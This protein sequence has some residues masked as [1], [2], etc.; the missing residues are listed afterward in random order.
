MVYEGIIQGKTVRLRSVEE[1]DAEITFKMRTDPEKAKY[2]HPVKGSVD[3]QRKFITKQ[4][5]TPGD[6]LFIIEDLQG[7]PIGMKGVY[8]YNETRNEV[9]TGRFIGYGS[10]IQNIEALVLS[11]DFA[12]DILK[13]DR[14]VMAALENN[15]MMLGIQKKFGVEF[16][17]RER[18][19][20]FGCDNLYSVLTRAAYALSRPNVSTLIDR[21]ANR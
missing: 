14:I 2:V 5:E 9:K 6:Y 19:E 11:F 13:V 12:F 10:Q 21:F 20:E 1:Q 8:D 16:T 4:R 17:H 7:N 15:K 18:C 3:E